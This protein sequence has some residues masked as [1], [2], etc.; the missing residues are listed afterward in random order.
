M[1]LRED[2]RK[3]H[4]AGAFGSKTIAQPRFAEPISKLIESIGAESVLDFGA[5]DGSGWGASKL[6]KPVKERLGDKLVFYDPGVPAHDK[7]PDGKFDVV[8]CVDVIEHVPEDEVDE[9]LR[10]IFSRTRFMV[11]L[12]FCPRG[13]RKKLPS[14]GADVHV[15]QKPRKWWESR[16]TTVNSTM[17]P[18]VPWYLFEN[19]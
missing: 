16:I 8:T 12:T 19:P 4:E 1:K 14:S 10:D 18:P 5:G 6:L 7:L 13:S 17:S 9:V 15:T 2:Y 11:I 3:L